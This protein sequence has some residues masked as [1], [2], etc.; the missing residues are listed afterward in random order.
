MCGHTRIFCGEHIAV[1]SKPSELKHLSNW[2]K[3]KKCGLFLA[4]V[5]HILKYEQ[6]V[7]RDFFARETVL[8]D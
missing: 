5:R 1:K 4:F 3:R 7:A 8:A 6:N 2:R